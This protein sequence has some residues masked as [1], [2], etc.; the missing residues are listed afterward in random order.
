MKR[1]VLGLMV[2]FG[3]G[4]VL[5][6]VE[7]PNNEVSLSGSGY[8]KQPEIAASGRNVYVC[9][10]QKADSNSLY[11]RLYFQRSSDGGRGWLNSP[12][13]IDRRGATA[14]G[15]VERPRLAVSGSYVYAIW[16]D[17]RNGK[18][19]IYLNYSADNGL[20]WLNKDIRIDAGDKPG[21][22]H[23]YVAE[24]AAAGA[25]VY[26]AWH[27]MRNGKADI[28]VNVSSDFGK[29][30]LA[31]P[32]RLDGDTPGA[33]DSRFVRLSAVNRKVYVVWQDDRNGKYDVYVNYSMNGGKDWLRAPVRLDRGNAA[34]AFDSVNPRVAAHQSAC[35]VVWEDYR[36]KNADIYVNCSHNNGANWLARDVRLDRGDSL[37]QND[38]LNPQLAVDGATVYVVWEDYRNEFSQGPFIYLNQSN[39]M[40]NSWLSQAKPL[41]SLGATAAQAFPQ[42]AAGRGL[43]YIVWRYGVKDSSGWTSMHIGLNF[44]KDRGVSWRTEEYW[45]NPLY[46]WSSSI[47]GPL[48]AG[49]GDYV[50]AA[51]TGGYKY[52]PVYYNGGNIFQLPE[53]GPLK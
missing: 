49:S 16:R 31:S 12:V 4:A 1:F 27:D 52:S 45:L 32:L 19:D 9:W 6:S 43:C 21:A 15:E 5:I 20:A 33:A 40:G 34:G 3:A 46:D 28:Y 47:G 22:S 36:R 23:G 18:S 14:K 35:Y 41:D 13:R 11:N 48:L 7:W 51:W 50:H 30:W 42:I 17:T 39:D 53:G 10:N 2:F 25:Y 29:T 37:G 38:S 8:I 44:S 26:V 24:I